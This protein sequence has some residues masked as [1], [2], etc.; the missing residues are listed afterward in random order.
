MEFHDIPGF[1]VLLDKDMN[2]A[3]PRQPARLSWRPLR[4]GAAYQVTS[5]HEFD[6]IGL[7][8]EICYLAA[9]NG[10][11]LVFVSPVASAPVRGGRF[12]LP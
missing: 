7:G 4:G 12:T 5:S 11:R 8:K 10:D 1:V 9:G 6:L 3:V 2:E